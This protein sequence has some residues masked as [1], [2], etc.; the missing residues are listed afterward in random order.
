MSLG[1]EQVLNIGIFLGVHQFKRQISAIPKR[2]LG[3]KAKSGTTCKV[4][5]SCF[6]EGSDSEDNLY[7]DS[8]SYVFGIVWNE[9]PKLEPTPN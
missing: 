7:D 4:N 9:T 6:T 1:P 3:K 8:F 2:F 5:N